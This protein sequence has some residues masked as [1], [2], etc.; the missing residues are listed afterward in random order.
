M[1][2]KVLMRRNEK[3][4]SLITRFKRTCERSNV[5]REYNKHKVYE[6][7][8]DRRKREKVSRRKNYQ[9]YIRELNSSSNTSSDDN[10]SSF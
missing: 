2:V 6:K 3:I 4:E 9:K 7:P 10:F 5:I 8:S 1:G